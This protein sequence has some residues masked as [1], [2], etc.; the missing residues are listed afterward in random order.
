MTATRRARVRRSRQR[1]VAAV[2]GVVAAA[3]LVGLVLFLTRP[4][5]PGSG[6]GGGGVQLNLGDDE[7]RAGVAERLA[8]R[9]ATDGRPFLIADASPAQARDIYLQHGG[10]D[11]EAGWL[12]FAARL[13]AQP[14][15]DCSLVWLD[16][17]G[18]FA[19]PCT[20]ERVPADGAGLTHYATEVRDGELFVD[21]RTEVPGPGG[22]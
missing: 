1:L 22:G 19:D 4:S 21:L 20:G 2:A 5:D 10:G 13:P 8:A 9:I 7:F 15:R 18:G 3:A 6:A 14:D 12:A 17:E 11:P 16:D